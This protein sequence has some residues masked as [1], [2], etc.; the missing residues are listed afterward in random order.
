MEKPEQSPFTK[1]I[2]AALQNDH[3]VPTVGAFFV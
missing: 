2:E 1:R 3:S